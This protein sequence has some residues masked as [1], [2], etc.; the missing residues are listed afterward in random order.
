MTP[1]RKKVVEDIESPAG[2]VGGSSSDAQSKTTRENARN[3]TS[4][5]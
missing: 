5:N 2:E 1:P 4:L 3:L